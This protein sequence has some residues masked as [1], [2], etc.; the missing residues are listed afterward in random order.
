MRGRILSKITDEMVARF[1]AAVG[2]SGTYRGDDARIAKALE[3]ALT[4]PP[5]PEIE[6]TEEM[7]RAGREAGHSV[8]SLCA[9]WPATIYRAMERVRL[10]QEM[11]PR[12]AACAAKCPESGPFVVCSGDAHTVAVGFPVGR[13]DDLVALHVGPASVLLDNAEREAVAWALK[14]PN[15]PKRASP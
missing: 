12:G 1:K 2:W 15:T 10:A 5:E 13:D 4:E 11:G 14:Y 9:D 7:R 6:V 8:P 3:A